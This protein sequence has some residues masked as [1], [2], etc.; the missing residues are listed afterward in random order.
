MQR[1][2]ASGIKVQEDILRKT[3]N[4]IKDGMISFSSVSKGEADCCI[5]SMGRSSQ[6]A[7][8]Q[9]FGG[10]NFLKAYSEGKVPCL[11]LLAS[12]VNIP[13]SK[14]EEIFGKYRTQ[15]GR[16]SGKEAFEALLQ[17]VSPDAQALRCRIHNRRFGYPLHSTALSGLME[18]K[19]VE[20]NIRA[21]YYNS[22]YSDSAKLLARISV[23]LST[24]PGWKEDPE[25]RVLLPVLRSAINT[26]RELESYR[27]RI[28]TRGNRC[29]V[30][31]SCSED[32]VLR[33]PAASITVANTAADGER[34]ERTSVIRDGRDDGLTVYTYESR[35]KEPL[36]M[37]R[38]KEVFKGMLSPDG[39]LSVENTLP[40]D[41]F[42]RLSGVEKTY[43]T[44]PK[45]QS[46][47][48]GETDRTDGGVFYDGM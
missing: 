43:L 18:N 30:I 2:Q 42:S 45:Q 31:L 1:Q 41:L 20:K 5:E 23:I 46:E 14:E 27:D 17:D 22:W 21:E 44:E 34:T 9:S 39:F 26:M 4:T 24:N 25:N 12:K 15:C 37:N 13:D 8:P 29:S 38:I 6:G 35:G 32:G 33:T 40:A 48:V 11:T 28:L 47:F 19:S 10:S 36:P 16:L 3:I 7:F